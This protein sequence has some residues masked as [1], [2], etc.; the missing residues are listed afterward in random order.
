MTPKERC[1]FDGFATGFMFALALFMFCYGVL[2]V[3]P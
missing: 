3:L 2:A 1:Y